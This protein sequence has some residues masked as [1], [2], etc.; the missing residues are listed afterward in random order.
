MNHF[1]FLILTVLLISVGCSTESQ[2]APSRSKPKIA[3]QEPQS[4]EG[5]Q[6]EPT[7]DDS[8]TPVV[9]E[10]ELAQEEIK[11]FLRGHFVISI[12]KLLLDNVGVALNSR[13]YR[14]TGALYP[15]LAWVS[16]SGIAQPAQSLICDSDDDGYWPM[17]STIPYSPSEDE[18][19]RLIPVPVSMM[20]NREL[21]L[22]LFVREEGWTT[23]TSSKLVE[24]VLTLKLSDINVEELMVLETTTLD[25]SLTDK[26]H[27]SNIAGGVVQFR[28]RAIAARNR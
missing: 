12:E 19:S 5:S 3:S 25:A 11:E 28:L 2:P 10:E 8:Q 26:T 22:R 15:N 9:S 1:Q 6:G 20:K 14:M 21:R 17:Q 7:Q 16:E 18:G 13:F 4:P 24:E 27:P 23:V